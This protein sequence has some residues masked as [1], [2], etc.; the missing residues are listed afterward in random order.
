M[1]MQVK[2]YE[3]LLECASCSDN[4]IRV[5]GVLF[6]DEMK[7]YCGKIIEIYNWHERNEFDRT[8]FAGSHE[9]WTFTE[10]MLKLA[11][12]RNGNNST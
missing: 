11:S 12:N 1:K 8:Y 7:R 10:N 4:N 3:E 6:P 5:D 9:D 2:T